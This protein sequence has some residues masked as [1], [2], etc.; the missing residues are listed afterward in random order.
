MEVSLFVSFWAFLV[1]SLATLLWDREKQAV[2]FKK[3]AVVFPKTS[4]HFRKNE[5]SILKIEQ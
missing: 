2:N 5:R 4:S 1:D 3:Q